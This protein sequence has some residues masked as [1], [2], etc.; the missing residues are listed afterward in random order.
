MNFFYIL[1]FLTIFVLNVGSAGQNKSLNEEQIIIEADNIESKNDN[2]LT[3]NGN[4]VLKKNNNEAYSEELIYDRK[5]KKIYLDKKIKF[6][7]NTKDVLFSD[8]SI[9]SDDLLT[10]TFGKSGIKSS[11][12]ITILADEIKKTDENTYIGTNT[13]YFICPNE[14]AN[15]DLNY[16][17]IVKNIKKTKKNI[18]SIES[19]KT[20]IDLLNKKIYLNHSFFRIFDVPVFYFPYLS[21]S[22]P[23]VKKVSGFTLPNIEHSNDYGYGLFVPYQLYINDYSKLKI[24]PVIYQHGSFAL[25]FDYKNSQKNKSISAKPLF[26]FDN[27]VSK[28][29][30]NDFGISE[31]NEGKYKNYRG[32]FNINHKQQLNK[33]WFFD[34][35]INFI[36]D[37]YLYRDYLDNYENN[38]DSEINLSRIN[39]DTY[40]YINF[41]AV[42]FQEI[43]E[44]A[45]IRQQTTP[46]FLPSINIHNTNQILTKNKENAFFNLDFKALTTDIF[47][48]NSNEY[49]RINFEPN[50][51]Y[52]KIINGSKIKTK[53]TIFND[54]YS[55]NDKYKRKNKDFETDFYRIVP[56]FSFDLRTPYRLFNN[57]NIIFEPIL[58]YYASPKTSNYD[59]KFIN[60]DAFG[61]EINILNLFS[62]NRFNGND[63]IEYGNR[64]NYGFISKIKSGLGNFG[65]SLGQAY[66]DVEKYSQTINGFDKNFSDVLTSFNYN[67]SIISLDFLTNFDRKEYGVKSNDLL[68]T[69]N[70]GKLDL[71]ANYSFIRKDKNILQSRN[72]KQ[73]KLLMNYEFY[74]NYNFSIDA[75]R[76]LEYNQTV[77]SNASIYFKNDCFIT[78]I[79]FR[80]NNYITSME[81]ADKSVNFYFVLLTDLF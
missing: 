52:N 62:G 25:R 49:T 70:F 5:N 8:K 35:K 77:E 10:G 23:F 42:G 14:Y 44:K 1:L 29:R 51:E 47:D 3:V 28:N 59:K 72:K 80:K 38:L 53:I 50:L 56:E 54:Y 60:E 21:T 81:K 78:G 46:Y 79:K 6:Y 74:E 30:L 31:K 66:K 64:I 39:F 24:E 41:N 12:N 33:N 57:Q 15:M 17:D 27:K 2:I 61:S 71:T 73:V 68:L 16:E 26:L 75:K 43:R 63:K 69:L 34:Y 18:F 19:K 40:N 22:K 65:F 36:T 9:V 48:I 20:K 76:D 4:V 55:L 37:E 32:Y 58:Q 67:Y 7:S 11:E 45:K 13:T